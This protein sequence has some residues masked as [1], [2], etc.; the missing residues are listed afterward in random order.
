ME[1]A[2]RGQRIPPPRR[3][4]THRAGRGRAR[5]RTR[6]RQRCLRS[7][8]VMTFAIRAAARPFVLA[9][10]ALALAGCSSLPSWLGGSEKAKPAELTT[11]PATL[12]VREA[13]TARVGGVDLPLSV[14]VQGSAITL[15]SSDGSIV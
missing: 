2:G 1:G 7:R 8:Q 9:L 6:A 15:G 5:T 14:N 12:A 11:N 10:C 3:S 4:E 13:W